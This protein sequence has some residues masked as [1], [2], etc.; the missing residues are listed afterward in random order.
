[1]DNGPLHTPASGV[2]GGDGLYLYGSGGFPTRSYNATNYWVD[3]VFSAAPADTPPVV[4]T[5]TPGAGLTGVSASAVVTAAFSEAV[6]PGS[7]AFTLTDP[8]GSPVAAAVSYDS[9]TATATLTPDAPLAGLSTYTVSVA[10]TDLAGTPMAAP[11]TWSFTTSAA[12]GTVPSSIWAPTAVPA[13]AAADDPNSVALGVKFR[14]DVVGYVTGLRFFKGAT[15][16]G[17]HVGHL[18]TSSGT[19]LAS[20][21]F[22]GET[23]TG[24]Q[25]VSFS[26]PVAVS[27]NTTYVAS[28]YSP[29]GSYAYNSGF[30]ATSGVDNG[31][32]H[33]LVSGQNSANGLYAYGDDSFPTRSY[34]SSNYWVD[35]VFS[36]TAGGDTV[37]PT[38]VRQAPAL[39]A[40]GVP[41]DAVATATFSE[42]VQTGSIAFELQDP[43][44]NPVA[45]T[46]SYDSATATATLT[47]SAPLA[48]FTTYTATVTAK[49]LAGTPMA[50]PARWSFA[51]GGAWQQTTAADF[52][53]GTADGTAVTNA[54][55]GEVQ[56]APGFA[57]DFTA[58]TLGPAWTSTP[59]L[60]GAGVSLSGS[61]LAVAGSEVLSAQTFADVPVEASLNFAAAPYQHFG[62]ATDLGSVDGNSWAIFSTRGTSNTLFAR[63]NVAGAVQDV[64]LGA[65]PAGFHVYRVQPAPGGVQFYLDGALQATINATFP[66][67]TPLKVA[68]S[69]YLPLGPGLQVD[70]VRQ[71][72][73]TFTSAVF[74]AG[75]SA[76]WGTARWTANVPAGTTLIVQT[77]SGNTAAP[78]GSWSAWATAGNGGAVASPGGRYLQYRV[79]LVTTDPSLTP[80][81]GDI[82]FSWI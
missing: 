73:G 82:A 21:T 49:D 44:G 30:F 68:L 51:T 17:T 78:D 35:I 12:A 38:V 81:L 46:V 6:Q 57:D 67:G 43:S 60:F 34:N 33:A 14:S 80:V 63:V 58:T 26:S 55:G 48:G 54:S 62:L 25:Q 71:T 56:L 45:A 59:W 66:A 9:A 23:A 72:G 41:T 8:S 3:V 1:V 29:N 74:D 18:W 24:W 50:T 7:I 19:L 61:V 31:P 39:G 36:T 2:D 75:R 15:N 27:A 70:W 28:Y 65:L 42:A 53:A 76:A 22:S 5:R 4:V 79:L 77:R 10:A 64:S 52:G 20:A 37:P 47:P 32:L 69:A 11:D 40:A 13:V 16:T